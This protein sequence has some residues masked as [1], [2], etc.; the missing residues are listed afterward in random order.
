[1]KEVL[2]NL[3]ALTLIEKHERESLAIE[4]ATYPQDYLWQNLGICPRYVRQRKVMAFVFFIPIVVI[5]FVFLVFID[6]FKKQI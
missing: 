3:S 4:R 6:I 1:M 2:G 5:I